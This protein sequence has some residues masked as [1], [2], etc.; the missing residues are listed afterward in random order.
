MIQFETL[1]RRIR[2]RINPASARAAGLTISAPLLQLAQI[3]RTED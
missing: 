2:L 1:D 3:D